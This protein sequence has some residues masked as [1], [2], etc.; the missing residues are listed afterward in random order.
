[1]Y[2]NTGKRRNL[3]YRAGCHNAAQELAVIDSLL[4]DCPERRHH[5]IPRE[6]LSNRGRIAQ[7][8]RLL[9]DFS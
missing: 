1:M 2:N 4:L 3:T 5:S 9:S 8:Q 7:R 6:L